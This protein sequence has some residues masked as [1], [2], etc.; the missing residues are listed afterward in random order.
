MGEPFLVI[1]IFVFT[2][3]NVFNLS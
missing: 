3:A 2:L 1:C